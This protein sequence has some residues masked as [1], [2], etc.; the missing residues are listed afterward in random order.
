[1]LLTGCKS[2]TTG[3]GT[4]G[5]KNIATKKNGGPKERAPGQNIVLDF[6]EDHLEAVCQNVDV[7]NKVLA[8]NAVKLKEYA[9]ASQETAAKQLV[10]MKFEKKA[11][12]TCFL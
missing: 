10:G 2:K 12:D 6:L 9:A 8:N 4:T 5:K 7:H 3:E 11:Q 1:V